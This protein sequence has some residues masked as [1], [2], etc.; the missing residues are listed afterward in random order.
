MNTLE[1]IF[2]KYR[3]SKSGSPYYIDVPREELGV[4]FKELM[5]RMGAEIGVEQG[6]YSEVLLKANPELKMY[7]IDAWKAYKGYR[8]HTNQEKLDR[9]FEE[10][11]KRLA[12][13]NC[14][15]IRDWSM[16]AVKKFKDDSLDFVYIDGNHDFKNVT[17]D[18]VEWSKKVRKDGIVAGHDYVKVRTSINCDV[19]AV[20]DAWTYVRRINP[21]FILTGNHFSSWMW[22]KE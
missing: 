20:V 8:D 22:V 9:Y 1:Y 5:F 15:I 21:Y 12:P 6:I 4:L 16:E 10:T 11:K 18:I 3:I 14:E 2:Q 19:K 7:C 17:N 13:Y